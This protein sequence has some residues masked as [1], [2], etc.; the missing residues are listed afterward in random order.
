MSFYKLTRHELAIHEAGHAYGFAAIE[1]YKTPISMGLGIDEAGASNGWSQR[2]TL[3]YTDKD[4]DRIHVE[5]QP[6]VRRQA[7]A[8]IVI[9]IAG[10]IADARY[11]LRSRW[12]GIFMILQN[13]ELFLKPAAFDIDG[14]FAKIRAILNY[15]QPFNSVEVFR[16]LIWVSEG[17]V[18]RNWPSIR[19]LSAHLREHGTLNAGELIEWFERYPAKRSHAGLDEALSGLGEIETHIA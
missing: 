1:R 14:D 2:D 6:F 7:A 12:A 11:R 5:S 13:A 10:P 8:E 16:N 15:I 3:L 17:I 18:T 4:F 19:R 9:S